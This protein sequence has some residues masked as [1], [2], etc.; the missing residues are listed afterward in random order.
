MGISLDLHCGYLGVKS[1]KTYAVPLTLQSPGISYSQA[2]PHSTSGNALLLCKRSYQFMAPALSVAGKDF[3]YQFSMS[4]SLQTLG[5]W[6]VCPAISILWWV[7]PGKDT[8]FQFVQLLFVAR[9][10]VPTFK[11]CTCQSQNWKSPLFWTAIPFPPSELPCPFLLYLSL[12]M[13]AESFHDDVETRLSFL[14]KEAMVNLLPMF[15]FCTCETS[16][17]AVWLYWIPSIYGLHSNILTVQIIWWDV[18][19]C[20][21]NFLLC[22]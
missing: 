19:Q 13:L 15:I 6:F 11:L 3:D 9:T 10:R 16:S 8:D 1:P 17:A 18:T 7:G 4:P 12:A 5:W 14:R 20:P 21:L 2:R 22:F